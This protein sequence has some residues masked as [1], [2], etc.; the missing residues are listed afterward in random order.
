MKLI[1]G[2]GGRKNSGKDMVCSIF[3]YINYKTLEQANYHDW[4]LNRQ[5]YDITLKNRVIHFADPVKDNLS[6][7]FG[8]NRKLFDDRYYKDEIWYDI[9]RG[10]FLEQKKFTL[11]NI[12]L[13]IDDFTNLDSFRKLIADNSEMPVIKLRTLMQVYATLMRTCFDDDIW[14]N[15]TIAKAELISQGRELCL[16][17]DVRYI[18]E[19]MAIKSV[20]KSST[21]IIVRV[22]RNIANINVDNHQSEED[23]F[24][25]DY[26][27]DNNST[28]IDTFYQCFNIY[29]ELNEKFNRKRK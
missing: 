21:G 12:K 27:I 15:S 7:M 29:K 20:R 14:V 2:V 10:I 4:E 25:A 24:D 3:N 16:I 28:I 18:N 8:I 19:A 13:V 9:R 6:V 5:Q 22:S 11:N 23:L 1:I 26:T 17:G